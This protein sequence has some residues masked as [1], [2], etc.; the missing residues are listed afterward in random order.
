LA[1]LETLRHDHAMSS[2]AEYEGLNVQARL[3]A[4][5]LTVEA[6]LRVYRLADEAVAE[7][8][9]HMWQWPTVTP[10]S[11][12]AWYDFD[13]EALQ[14]AE[15][16]GPLAPQV[17]LA[18]QQ[19]GA[20]AAD[21]AVMLADVVNIVYDS[22]FGA[23]DLTLSLARLRNIEDVACRTGISLPAAGRFSRF[24]AQDKHGWGFPVS[25]VQVADW[26]RQS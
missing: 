21:L 26:R 24:R 25:A 14:A 17:A 16:G 19:R 18:C 15:A 23:L 13:S 20:P 22:L 4:G 1:H 12:G 9:E 11:F 6:W 3:V 8:L 2:A 10:D 5:L 7:L